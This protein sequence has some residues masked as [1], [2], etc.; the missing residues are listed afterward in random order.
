MITSEKELQSNSENIEK[1]KSISC[2]LIDEMDNNVS[3]DNETD[4]SLLK[5]LEL[6]KN[7]PEWCNDIINLELEFNRKMLEIIKESNLHLNK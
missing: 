2:N 3:T 6:M 1:L 4:E 7:G 5:F